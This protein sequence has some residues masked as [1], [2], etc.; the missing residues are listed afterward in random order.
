[1]TY[2]LCPIYNLYIFSL[3]LFATYRF[4]LIDRGYMIWEKRICDVGRNYFTFT[5]LISY[6]TSLTQLVTITT[7]GDSMKSRLD[8]NTSNYFFSVKINKYHEESIY[9]FV[10]NDKEQAQCDAGLILRQYS[11]L[12]VTTKGHHHPLK[13]NELSCVL[14]DL[15]TSKVAFNTFA[16]NYFDQKDYLKHYNYLNL[17]L[18]LEIRI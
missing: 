12:Q 16:D 17:E 1:M 14:Q 5:T 6:L 7:Q 11:S 18:L 10:L 3:F 2:V 15:K 4:K 13:E 9:R 8:I